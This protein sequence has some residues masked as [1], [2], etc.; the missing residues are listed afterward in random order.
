MAALLQ[1]R[2][3]RSNRA[4]LEA[5]VPVGLRSMEKILFFPHPLVI[6]HLF[7]GEGYGGSLVSV[8]GDVGLSGGDRSPCFATTYANSKCAKNKRIDEKSFHC[9]FK[10]KLV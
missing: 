2:R 8:L 9:C 10:F 5:I 4:L 1:P 3:S 6:L 7:G